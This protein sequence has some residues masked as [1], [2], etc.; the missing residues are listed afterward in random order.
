[1]EVRTKKNKKKK[2]KKKKKTCHEIVQDQH[3][4][5]IFVHILVLLH[6]TLNAKFRSDGSTGSV[7]EKKIFLKVF[8]YHIWLC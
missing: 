6:Q 1:M 2:T 8:F 3:R 5:I 7:L 4:V